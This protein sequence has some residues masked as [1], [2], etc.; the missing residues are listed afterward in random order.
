MLSRAL[1]EHQANQA[2]QREKQEHLRREA[3]VASSRLTYKL[4]DTLNTGVEQA[5]V[6]QRKLETEAK[7]LQAHAARFSKQTVQWLQM[8][9]AFNKALK[10]LGDVE[11]WSRVIEADMTAIASALEY[12]YKGDGPKA[13]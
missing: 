13:S 12:A 6:N 2:V 11:N 1:K 4:M 10:E 3:V 7:Q 8:L 9:E 5:Y